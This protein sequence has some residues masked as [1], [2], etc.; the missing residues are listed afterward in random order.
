MRIVNVAA[1]VQ[2]RVYVNADQ[3]NEAGA[4]RMDT[5]PTGC[6]CP[7]TSVPGGHSLLT[8][9]KALGLNERLEHRRD[10]TEREG[11]H[12]IEARL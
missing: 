8:T 12:V 1:Q 7:S 6:E 10:G 3:I 11:L 4:I 5:E 2:V 9:V